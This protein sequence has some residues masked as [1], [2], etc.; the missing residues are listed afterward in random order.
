MKSE[1]RSATTGLTHNG[2]WKGRG[3]PEGVNGTQPVV[4]AHSATTGSTHNGTWKGRGHPEGVNRI[5]PVLSAQRHHRGERA[6]RTMKPRSDTRLRGRPPIGVTELHLHL[7]GSLAP[8]S[9]IE[10]AAARGHEWGSLRPRELRK[11]L[12]YASFDEFLTV[13]REMCVILS[14]Y[15]AIERAA[16]ELSARLAHDG[17][18][19]AEVYA[20]PYIFVRWGMDF[21]E[22]LRAVDRGFERAEAEGLTRCTILLDSVR[23]W[24]A[25]AAEIVLDGFE[26]TRLARVV[27]FGLGGEESVPLETFREVYA[28]A[29]GLGLGTV[30]HAGESGPASDV[31]IAID[32]LRTDRVAH[33]IRAIDDATVL[34]EIVARKIP[35]DLAIT[36]NYRT[37]VV[38]GEHP[39]R[40]LLDAGAVVTLSTDDPSLFRTSLPREYARASMFGSARDDELWQIAHNGIDAAFAPPELKASLHRKAEG[41]RHEQS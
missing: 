33:G 18:E 11:R 35:L 1:E 13:I 30:V 22:T 15:D 2:T 40:R 16:W 20:S 8:E 41:R 9:A 7:E 36:S 38:S 28:R 12:R 37:A 6:M 21:G 26:K 4:S 25:E 14:S 10:I 19:Y 23:Q 31:R 32:G 29:R 34:D 39:I 17:V 3:H 5:Q 24:G 27:G